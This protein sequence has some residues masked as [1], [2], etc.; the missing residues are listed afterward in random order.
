MASRRELRGAERAIVD[1]LED[2]K[3]DGVLQAHLARLTGYSKST[4][5]EAL[6]RLERE[7]VVVRGR[8]G[9]EAL[10]WL[11]KYRPAE[12]VRAL[13]LGFI[14]ALEYAYLPLLRK[15]LRSRGFVVELKPYGNG[16]LV[17]RDLAAGRLELAMAPL[18]TQLAYFAITRG[19]IRIIAACGRGGSS[20]VSAPGVASVRDLE[21]GPVGCTAFS[22]M[23]A[24]LLKTVRGEGVDVASLTVR[25]Y[26]SGEALMDGLRRGEVG[27]VSIW[28]PYATAL[29]RSGFR[30]AARYRESVG[31]FV[32]CVLSCRSGLQGVE[33]IASC[34]AQAVRDFGEGAE[35]HARA[36]A[37][38]VGIPYAEEALED[39]AFDPALSPADVHR[40]LSQLGLEALSPMAR[41][42]LLPL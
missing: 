1:A 22:T 30:R 8:K 20:L 6:S 38:L 23:E 14:R 24:A 42:S 15:A 33:A 3:E 5:S 13:R 2:A 17:L 36:Y 41:E 18:I 28:E 39:L 16:L 31:D 9:R 29:A 27:A 37:E 12:E 34:Y 7:G 40:T 21:G 26:D 11:S 35:G 19:A 4:V 25:H 10:V 32:C